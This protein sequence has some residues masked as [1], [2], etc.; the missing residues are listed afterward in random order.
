MA[1]E[2]GKASG[3]RAVLAVMAKRDWNP[4]RL[5]TEA[6]ID[7]G[8]AGDFLNGKRWP[9]VGTLGKI[10]AAVGWTP[11]TLAAIGEELQAADVPNTP[12][13]RTIP[14]PELLAEI[15]RRLGLDIEVVEGPVAELPTPPK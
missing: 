13:A 5:A 4:A 10:D 2:A 15:A 3:R 8:T 14:T 7:Y 1:T 9:K 11:G 6:G 12:A